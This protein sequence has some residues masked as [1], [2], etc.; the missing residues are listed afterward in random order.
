MLN[1]LILNL[2][3]RVDVYLKLTLVINIR[4]KLYNRLIET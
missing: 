2:F 1:I 3:K 4:Q